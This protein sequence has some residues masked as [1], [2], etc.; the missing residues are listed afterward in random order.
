MTVKNAKSGKKPLKIPFSI[1]GSAKVANIN[2]KVKIIAKGA[3]MGSFDS[4][5]LILSFSYSL[6]ISHFNTRL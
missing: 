4:F 6:S 5:K 2:A 1:P 3:K